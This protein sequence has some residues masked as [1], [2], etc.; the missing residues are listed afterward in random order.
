[1]SMEPWLITLTVGF[2]FQLGFVVYGYGRLSQKVDGI[3]KKLGDGYTCR[4]HADITKDIGKLQG[5]LDVA[6]HS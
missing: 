1:M 4:F 5:E 3:C 6:K 2:L